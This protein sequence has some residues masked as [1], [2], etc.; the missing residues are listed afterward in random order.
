MKKILAVS[1]VYPDRLNNGGKIRLHH[2]FGGL[3]RLGTVDLLTLRR[4]GEDGNAA[5]DEAFRQVWKF[6]NRAG[7]GA[8][9]RQW[10]RGRRPYRCLLNN[11]GHWV[12]SGFLTAQYQRE[13]Y[14]MVVAAFTESVAWLREELSLP[15]KRIALDQHNNEQVWADSFRSRGSVAGKLFGRLNLARLRRWEPAVH[16][17]LGLLISCSESDRQASLQ[18][19]PSIRRS[20]V[21]ENGLTLPTNTFPRTESFPLSPTLIFCGSLDVQMNVQGLKS[22]LKRDWPAL[23]A[24]LDC[25]LLVVGR[26][27]GPRLRRLVDASRN[28]T[29]HA[30]VP[31][32][33]EYYAK[34]HAALNP[35]SIGGGGK[36]KLL[37][38]MAHGLRVIS[39]SAGVLGVPYGLRKYVWTWDNAEELI[40]RVRE[41]GGT[42]LPI[43]HSELLKHDW[44]VRQDEFVASV[45][46]AL[47]I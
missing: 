15:G 46:G 13:G 10:L 32:V 24:E 40:R 6:E 36:I 27:P 39:Q 23:V 20:A 29:L 7:I 18:C 11:F 45:G 31:A 33:A 17:D 14:D 34:A 41:S 35:V 5:F 25:R 12:P 38:A 3:H 1:P 28:V 26:N 22:F 30:D 2:L 16:H 19:H 47:S 4:S 37:E 9:R 43:T 44:Q 8:A 21:V 42:V